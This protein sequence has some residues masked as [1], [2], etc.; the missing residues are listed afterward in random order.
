M[1]APAAR[2]RRELR[3]HPARPPPPAK[4]PGRAARSPQASRLALRDFPTGRRPGPPRVLHRAQGHSRPTRVDPPRPTHAGLPRPLVRMIPPAAHGAG[5][6]AV[7]PLRA[8]PEPKNGARPRRDDETVAAYPQEST[9]GPHLHTD[10]SPGH[11][12]SSPVR[13]RRGQ[14]T[15]AH[16]TDHIP[17]DGRPWPPPGADE[18]YTGAHESPTRRST[19]SQVSNQ[20][21]KAGFRAVSR[22]QWTALCQRYDETVSCQRYP[23]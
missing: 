4:L 17:I 23:H 3:T 11:P 19:R 10:S 21:L 9:G 20:Q 22:A 18:L 7:R 13:S 14:V 2:R 15:K 16:V 6:T 12:A 5:R 1:V 8:Q